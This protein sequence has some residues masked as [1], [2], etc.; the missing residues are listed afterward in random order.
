M[1]ENNNAVTIEVDQYDS[2]VETETKYEILTRSMLKSAQLAFDRKSLRFDD[3]IICTLLKVMLG[4][5]YDSKLEE[6]QC[7]YKESLCAATPDSTTIK[8]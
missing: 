2:L 1:N 3:E 5:T 6:L 4:Y 7:E 8:V